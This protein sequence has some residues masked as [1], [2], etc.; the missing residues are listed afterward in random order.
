MKSFYIVNYHWI[1]VIFKLHLL[2]NKGGGGE[3]IKLFIFWD[4]PLETYY[5]PTMGKYYHKD[6][7]A[8]ILNLQN[9]LVFGIFWSGVK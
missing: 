6:I 8:A 5:A 3:A 4:F 2:L 1:K 9:L 7:L